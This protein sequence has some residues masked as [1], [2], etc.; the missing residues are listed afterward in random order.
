MGAG[1]V[2]LRELLEL[3][4]LDTCLFRGR[5]R[6]T[7]STR[8]FGG[9]VA[10]Q[11]L[12]AAGRTVPDDRPVHSL[13]AYFLRPGDPAAPI[14]YQVDEI[15]D[16]GSFTTRRAV[17]VQHGRPIFQ[18]SASF[19]RPEEGYAYQPAPS[20]RPVPEELPPAEE[21]IGG[22]DEGTRQWF[23]RVH[24][25][26]PLEVRFAGELARFAALRGE[27]APPLQRFWFRTR[28]ELGDDPLLHACA[29]V[30][31]SDL[32]LLTTAVAPHGLVLDT[33]FQFASLDHTLWLHG[34]PRAD[35]W[36]FYE[37]EGLW[38]GSARALCRGALSDRSGRLVGN[39]M[40]EGLIRP[41]RREEP[42]SLAESED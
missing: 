14:V 16:G 2:G 21:V 37:Q 17:A 1:T 39:V 27:P 26:L 10:A 35:D 12:M 19:H 24:H 42:R 36:L 15:R 18:L 40:Q 6:P 11:A 41:L 25:A 22:A 3:E 29:V 28:E 5:S 9:E 8:V 32:L 31:A 13:H 23:A 7:A 4:R 33:S 20:E 38:S 34:A 30:Y